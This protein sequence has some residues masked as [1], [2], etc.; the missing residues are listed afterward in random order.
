MHRQ[1]LDAKKRLKIDF[2]HEWKYIKGQV[3]FLANRVENKRAWLEEVLVAR[4][5]VDE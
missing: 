4:V 1:L 5:K 3:E 2:S